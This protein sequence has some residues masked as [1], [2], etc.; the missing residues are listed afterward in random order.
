MPH[1]Y[2]FT[3]FRLGNFLEQDE[4][5]IITILID[6]PPNTA[7]L[8]ETGYSTR[9]LLLNIEDTIKILYPITPQATSSDT[10]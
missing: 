7:I 3:E 6:P 5:D 10:V 4:N 1:E 9:N 8:L 2:F